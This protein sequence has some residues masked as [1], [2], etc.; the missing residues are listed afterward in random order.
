MAAI[1]TRTSVKVLVTGATGFVGNALCSRLSELGYTVRCAVR[2]S[3]VAQHSARFHAI[4]IGGLGP[5]T[6]WSEALSDVSVVFHLAARTHVLKETARD[7]LTEYRRIN[8]EGTRALTQ[9]ATRAGVRRMVFLSS[10]KVNGERT[11]A[12]PFNE[13]MA[14]QPEDAYGISKWEAEQ[15]LCDASHDTPLETAI[16][17]CPLVYGPGVKGNFLRLL[18]WTAR[19]L[20]LP[21]ASVDNHRS[22][23]FVENLVDALVA[24]GTLPAAARQ[25]YLV[26]DNDDVSTPELIR[27]ISNALHVRAH[28]FSC[29]PALLRTAAAALGKREELRRLTDSLQIDNSKIRRELAWMP[30][31]QLAASLV[32]TAQWYHAQF[33]VKSNT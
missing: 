11:D 19:G 21:L 33:P 7:A 16:L 13:K 30:R 8:V 27:S 23:I 20:P 1:D 14:P 22:L 32:R 3:T 26:S 10:I 24:A 15:A 12:T 9:A 5:D 2:T 25:T 6:D 18:H 4:R 29:P 31:F 17:R 28:L